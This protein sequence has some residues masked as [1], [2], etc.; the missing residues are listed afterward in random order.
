MWHIVYVGYGYWY[1]TGTAY[2]Y[3]G[4]CKSKR[5]CQPNIIKVKLKYHIS[6]YLLVSFRQYFR[7]IYARGCSCGSQSMRGT[8]WVLGQLFGSWWNV[9]D[10]K[11]LWIGRVYRGVIQQDGE[12]YQEL[13]VY[14]VLY[15]CICLSACT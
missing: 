5:Q 13:S 8:G 1:T 15:L 7:G 9:H 2:R 12:K 11:L 6:S 4:Q 14:L 10:W 3:R